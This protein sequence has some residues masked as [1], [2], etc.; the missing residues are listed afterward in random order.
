[1]GGLKIPPSCLQT[2][3]KFGTRGVGSSCH[4][5]RL[6]LRRSPPIWDK[7]TIF[8]L[9]LEYQV[10]P[11]GRC[12]PWWVLSLY[13]GSL[14]PPF[15]CCWSCASFPPWPAGS[16]P[17]HMS[18]L[19]V[20][21]GVCKPSGLHGSRGG[22]EPG[23]RPRWEEVREFGSAEGPKKMLLTMLEQLFRIQHLP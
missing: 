21:C 18:L 23:Q 16:Y 12:H 19:R 10:G 14:G 6:H 4:R 15:P 9:D 1:M 17:G 7:A 22:P 13:P 11:R 8:C 3:C 5:G 20:N 2:L